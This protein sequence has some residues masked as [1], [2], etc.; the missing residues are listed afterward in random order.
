V[1]NYVIRRMVQALPVVLGITVITFALA[2]A[3]PGDPFSSI[4]NPRI[5]AASLAHMR[6]EKGLLDPLPVQYYHWLVQLLH[7]NLGTS[8]SISEPVTQVIADRLPPTLTLDLMALIMALLATVPLGVISAVRQYS[9][10]DHA[11]TLISFLGI[12]T[13]VF[14][15][16]LLALKFLALTWTIFPSGGVITPGVTLPFPQNQLDALHHLILPALIL[17]FAQ[18]AGFVRYLRASMLEVV[19]QDFVRTARSKGLGERV[20]VYKHALRNAVIP[21]VTLLGLSL[22]GLFSG[23]ILTETVFTIPGI[24]YTLYQG[25][26]AR[27]Y[28]IILGI[29]LMLAILTV[30]GNL[31]A[32]VA[33]ALV[34]PRIRFD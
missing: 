19:R 3:M 10:L 4:L 29:T 5:N 23:G 24:A 12:A 8:F 2:K 7:G 26:I 1:R 25:V 31:L 27:D 13:P 28:P 9:T 22:P 34:D 30:V 6:Y 32:D 20:V 15:V 21:L 33:Y 14:F 17:A 16:A 11:L 18:A